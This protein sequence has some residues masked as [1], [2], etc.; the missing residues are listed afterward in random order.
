MEDLPGDPGLR[1]Q[2]FEYNSNDQ[3]RIR[4]V[5]LEKGLCQPANH[6][7]PRTL[8]SAN[9]SKNQLKCKKDVNEP[10]DL[11]DPLAAEENDEVTSYACILSSTKD[12]RRST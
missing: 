1:N 10:E 2:I 6:K 4:R 12:S 7:F 8:I 11:G 9:K 5:Y 3:D